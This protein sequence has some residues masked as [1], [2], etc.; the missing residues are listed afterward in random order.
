MRADDLLR[1]FSGY[2]GRVVSNLLI[3]VVDQKADKGTFKGVRE[4]PPQSS[5][6]VGGRLIGLLR[7]YDK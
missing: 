7:Q 1:G 2:G 4:E 6:I 3:S 5:A